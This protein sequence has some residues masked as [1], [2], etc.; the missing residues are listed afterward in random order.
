MKAR[1]QKGVIMFKRV[2]A[3][4]I[5]S[6]LAACSSTG[7]KQ[8]EAPVTESQGRPPVTSDAGGKPPPPADTGRISTVTPPQVDELTTGVLA[9]RSVYFDLDSYEVKGEY[10]SLVE[11]HAAFLRKN[12]G[13][14]VVVEGNTDERGSREYNLS[15]GQKRA[16]AVKK[17]LVLLGVPDSQLEAVSFGEEKPKAP[18]KD[19]SAYAENRR[20]DLSYRAR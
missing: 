10:R 16:E 12:P 18:G 19:E 13:R 8:P 17:M 3:I 5:V 6:L 20:G 4:T 1:N 11:A 9:K 15:L 7:D 2:S 14:K